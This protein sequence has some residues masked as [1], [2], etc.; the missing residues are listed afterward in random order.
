[1][2]KKFESVRSDAMKDTGLLWHQTM[3]PRHFQE[4][5]YQI[6]RYKLRTK[7]YEKRKRRK[8]GHNRPLVW[9]GDLMKAVTQSAAFHVTKSSVKIVMSGP[10]WLAGYIAMSGKT[11]KVRDAQGNYVGR[12]KANYPDKKKELTRVMKNEVEAMAK[13]MKHRFKDAMNNA[14][15]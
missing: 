14:K 8:R 4:N 11:K 15:G 7:S 5:A 13:L 6:Y 3:L 1:M 12:T 10:K 2:A 9:K